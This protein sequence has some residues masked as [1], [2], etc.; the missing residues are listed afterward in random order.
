M[1]NIFFEMDKGKRSVLFI[2][3]LIG[4]GKTFDFIHLFD[5]SNACGEWWHWRCGWGVVATCDLV[6]AE[7]VD[8]GRGIEWGGGESL[9]SK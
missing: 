6:C 2:R 3:N 5:I 1:I 8:G 4:G 9:F 7:V